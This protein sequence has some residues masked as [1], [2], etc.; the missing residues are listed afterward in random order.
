MEAI[1]GYWGLFAMIV[2]GGY[3]VLKAKEPKIR[4]ACLVFLIMGVWVCYLALNSPSP[5]QEN[6]YGDGY[7]VSFRGTHCSGTLGCSCSG[8]EPITNGDI[9]QENYCRHCNHKKSSHR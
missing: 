9:W 5:S 1:L 3:G 4:I 2:G 8:F 6:D 7:N